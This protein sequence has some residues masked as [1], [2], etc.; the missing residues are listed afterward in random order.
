MGRL[1][2]VNRTFQVPY[3]QLGFSTFV[4]SRPFKI[5]ETCPLWYSKRIQVNIG[6]LGAAR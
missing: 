6:E 3:E 5:V 4:I 1:E 2:K